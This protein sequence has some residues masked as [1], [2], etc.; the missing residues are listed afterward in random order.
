MSTT[1]ALLQ[2][3][4]DS[5][6]YCHWNSNWSCLLR[7]GGG[8]WRRRWRRRRRRLLRCLLARSSDNVAARIIPKVV[9]IEVVTEEY[10]LLGGFHLMRHLYAQLHGIDLGDVVLRVAQGAAAAQR[11]A[12]TAACAVL[13]L[14][15]ATLRDDNVLVDGIEIVF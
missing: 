5:N 4:H 2:R 15:Q 11:A 12:A 9:E 13:L 1:I 8:G 6:R 7:Q 3:H 10:L 14:P